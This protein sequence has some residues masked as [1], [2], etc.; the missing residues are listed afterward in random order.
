MTAT[1]LPAWKWQGRPVRLVDDTSAPMADTPTNQAAFPQQLQ[2][3]AIATKEIWVHLL[4]YNVMMLQTASTE[5]LLP[6]QLSFRHALQHGL[7]PLLGASRCEDL[8]SHA[9]SHRQTPRWTTIWTHPNADTLRA[10]KRELMDAEVSAIHVRDNSCE[11]PD[12]V[13]AAQRCK[14]TLVRRKRDSQ[15]R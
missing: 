15:G 8:A 2:E 13:P 5:D 12:T 6:R 1:A 11:F 7:P 9:A 3:P 14:P 10:R 4:A